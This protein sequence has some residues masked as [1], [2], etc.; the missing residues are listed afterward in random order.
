MAESDK[1]SVLYVG[2]GSTTESLSKSTSSYKT[3]DESLGP[4]SRSLGIQFNRHTILFRTSDDV[5][6]ES[7]GFSTR[8]EFVKQVTVEVEEQMRE[9][10]NRYLSEDLRRDTFVTN[11]YT[12][13]DQIFKSLHPA[14]RE[15][16]QQKKP[17]FPGEELL[18]ELANEIRYLTLVWVRVDVDVLLGDAFRFGQSSSENATTETFIIDIAK[19]LKAKN[20]RND[21]IS[22][23][24]SFREFTIAASIQ[25]LINQSSLG[26]THRFNYH[27]C[28]LKNMG[29]FSELIVVRI[30]IIPRLECFKDNLRIDQARNHFQEHPIKY[31]PQKIKK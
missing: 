10:L 19:G 26:L 1:K 2:K 17:A 11:G 6:L 13:F 9:S 20:K 30:I 25:I 12:D 4:P 5:S 3:F 24:Q 8:D 22:L 29:T 18:K 28:L 15:R 31:I 14:F 21:A 27:F 16:K 7:K 23:L